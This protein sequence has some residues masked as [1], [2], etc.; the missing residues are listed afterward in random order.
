MAKSIL[1]IDVNDAKFKAF[2][3]AFEK[4]KQSVKDVP[5]SWAASGAAIGKAGNDA[6]KA[7]KNVLK[8]NK[9][10]IKSFDDGH[11]KLKNVAKTSG[12]IAINFAS[13]ALSVAKWVT[14]SGL[15]SGFGLGALAAAASGTS[16]Q[17]RG[18]GVTTGELRSASTNY[19][20]F[21]GDPS[22]TLSKIA[23]MQNDLERNQ[24]L[25]RL[26]G[27]E[28]QNAAQQ[29]PELFKNA[30]A[31]FK[32]TGQKTQTADALGLTQVFSIEDLRRGA[33]ATTEQLNNV[34]NSFRKDIDLLSV[35]E[36]DS[37]AM[38]N[39]WIQIKRSGEQ[40]E[41]GFIKALTPLTPQLTALS[42]AVTTAITDFIGSKQVK[43]AIENF[44]KYL[45]SPEARQD[46]A[47]FFGAIKVISST[48]MSVV[49]FFSGKG[50]A[51]GAAKTL[52]DAL[53]P[54]SAI[55]NSPVA[56]TVRSWLN[57][58]EPKGT[59]ATQEHGGSIGGFIPIGTAP[60]IGA[61][62]ISKPTGD[63]QQFLAN[64][65][66]KNKLPAGI[67]DKT[68]Q[69]ESG[70]GK[71]MNSPVGAMGHFQFMPATAKEYG[72]KN[73]YDF[74]DSAEAAAKKIKGLL[75]RYNGDIEK[76][77]GAYN[78]G[79]G[80]MDKYVS[81]RKYSM[82]KETQNYMHKFDVV[83]NNAAGSDLVVTSNGLR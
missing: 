3:A 14:L 70:R 39:F 29:L 38:T 50:F 81:G 73:P 19:G 1:E 36:A 13:T 22:S 12:E 11:Q 28:G 30:V 80:N 33:Q 6:D 51:G 2:A 4:Y 78:W 54:F 34:A 57:P 69:V 52:K 68:W 32:A 16:K 55:T 25:T 64:L 58:N 75:K 72:L 43:E 5:K 31:Q 48:I 66:A 17:A 56:D 47:D 44:T 76:A 82:P 9:D 49:N 26:G 27:K 37:E 65:E 21:I 63:A 10:L 41:T 53:N 77:M 42:A 35:S 8:T 24:I 40:L 67:L 7:F 61:S 18:I 59:P 46:L 23:D 20:K 79:E 15:A 60:P 45:G 71:N 83:V 74:H 62:S